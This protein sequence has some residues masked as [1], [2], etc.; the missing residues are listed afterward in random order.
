VD[1]ANTETEE[2]DFDLNYAAKVAHDGLKLSATTASAETGHLKACI[3]A[4]NTRQSNVDTDGILDSIGFASSRIP[5]TDHDQLQGHHQED[6]QLFSEFVHDLQEM[7]EFLNL[8]RIP[9]Q[10]VVSWS[11]LL[12]SPG[13]I[14]LHYPPSDSRGDQE[15]VKTTMNAK[16]ICIH[17]ILTKMGLTGLANE[18]P[19]AWHERFFLKTSLLWRKH[20]Q[21]QPY[22][23]AYSPEIVDLNLNFYRK[24]VEVSDYNVRLIYGS[25]NVRE[26]L[27]LSTDDDRVYF[28]LSETPLYG[29]P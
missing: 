11:G 6:D 21:S 3:R 19:V 8:P 28:S 25:V 9:P 29:Q 1:D 5:H 26:D 15:P 12:N 22:R 4:S 14:S 20:N 10:D 13:L 2:L 24:L 17:N 18:M 27:E 23:A 7:C 16:N